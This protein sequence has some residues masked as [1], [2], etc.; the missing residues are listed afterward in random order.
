MFKWQVYLA[1]ICPP[2]KAPERGR[3]GRDRAGISPW[4]APT[5][6]ESAGGTGVIRAM[7][8]AEN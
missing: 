4:N 7:R 6:R 2:V 1:G 3:R 5:A 8:S